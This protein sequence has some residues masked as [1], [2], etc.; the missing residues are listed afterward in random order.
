MLAALCGAQIERGER[1]AA[2]LLAEGRGNGGRRMN[3]GGLEDAKPETRLRRCPS[4]QIGDCLSKSEA[5]PARPAIQQPSNFMH[6]ASGFRLYPIA[7]HCLDPCR[8]SGIDSVCLRVTGF[9]RLVKARYLLG[10]NG[11]RSWTRAEKR[12][13]LGQFSDRRVRDSVWR[14]TVRYITCIPGD[15]VYTS[16]PLNVPKPM[17]QSRRQ[18]L[19]RITTPST[20]EVLKV[21]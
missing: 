21:T 3:E 18:A 19:N 8:H 7:R 1:S 10:C 17:T 14:I 20:V 4:C 9:Y 6:Y 5:R 15:F 2:W 16:N 13:A 12:S 11:E